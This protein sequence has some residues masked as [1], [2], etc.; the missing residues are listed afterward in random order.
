MGGDDILE[1]LTV[2]FLVVALACIADDNDIHLP[3]LGLDTPEDR[4]NLENSKTML[5]LFILVRTLIILKRGGQ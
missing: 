4:Q 3:G 2:A 1:F 5:G